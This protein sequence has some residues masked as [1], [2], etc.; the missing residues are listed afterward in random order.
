MGIGSRQEALNSAVVRSSQAD[1]PSNEQAGPVDVPLACKSPLMN[2]R[3]EFGPIRGGAACGGQWPRQ[4][5]PA[6]SGAVAV[7][8]RSR[9]AGTTCQV[10]VMVVG[11]SVDRGHL[12]GRGRRAMSEPRSAFGMLLVAPPALRLSGPLRRRPL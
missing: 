2:N 5:G 11:S 1:A 7:L 4:P 8:R 10:M 9:V 12:V 6:A 3:R